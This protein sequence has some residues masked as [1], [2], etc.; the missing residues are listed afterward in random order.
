MVQDL[1]YQLRKG[2]HGYVLDKKGDDTIRL[3]CKNVN[4]LSLFHP[5]KSQQKKLLNLHNRYQM[6]G[7]CILKQ[8]TFL[9]MAPDGFCSDDIFD[10]YQGMRVMAAH[11]VHEQ[12]SRYQ[13]GGTLTA[14]FTRLSGFVKAIGLDYTGLGRW[15]WVQVGTGK[16]HT[17]IV[18][19][20]QPCQGSG[21]TRLGREGQVLHGKTVASKHSRYFQK[22]ESPQTPERHSHSNLSRSYKHSEQR[23][24]E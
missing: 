3:R 12:H 4:S 9:W 23:G 19:A 5:T 21:R 10:A 11:N 17:Q 16:H 8:S 7:A 20:Y 22:R 18:L 24:R 14:S 15:S 6:N 1:L 13:Q 2:G